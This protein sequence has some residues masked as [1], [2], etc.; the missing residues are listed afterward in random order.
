[1][2]VRI[3]IYCLLTFI[4][5]IV[6]IY[7]SGDHM[8]SLDYVLA[9]IILGIQVGLTGLFIFTKSK[10][11]DWLIKQE[12]ELGIDDIDSIECAVSAFL[13]YSLLIFGILL[14]FGVYLN[15][16]MEASE[17]IFV[18]SFAL[19]TCLELF[20]SPFYLILAGESEYPKI[21]RRIFVV[22]LA[23]VVFI[24]VFNPFNF[25]QT[26]ATLVLLTIFCIG[27][28]LFLGSC[29]YRERLY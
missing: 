19:N 26:A 11:R 10:W 3:Y 12:Y 27:S 13:S 6:H 8:T 21:L 4:Y 25:D 28:L 20:Q 14:P 5:P 17:I 18:F 1:M 2:K 15:R 16:P 29:F 9:G 22:F 23:I 7:F 24:I